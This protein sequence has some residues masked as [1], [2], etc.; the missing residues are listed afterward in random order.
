MLMSIDVQWWCY[1]YIYFR[2]NFI[3]LSVLFLCLFC[4]L[5]SIYSALSSIIYRRF[6]CIKVEWK[7][8]KIYRM[9]I[10]SIIVFFVSAY[11]RTDPKYV[12]YQVICKFAQNIRQIDVF[13]YGVLL[14][15][16][17]WG[18]KYRN[19]HTYHNKII[20]YLICIN[21]IEMIT[22]VFVQN[23]KGSKGY[24][25]SILQVY[26]LFA[27]IVINSVLQ[28]MK[29]QSNAKKEIISESFFVDKIQKKQETLFEERQEQL[30]EIYKKIHAYS[31]EEQMT[32]FV[33][34][35]WGGG[36]TFFS[37]ILY[38]KLKKTDNY[39]VI[40][41]DMNDFSETDILIKQIL[42]KIQLALEENNYYVG[43]SSEVEKYFDAVL[44]IT[45][46]KSLAKLISEYLKNSELNCI[47]N[48][49]SLTKMAQDF[50][51]M[52]GEGKIV[53]ILDDLDRCS[54]ETI[55]A[56]V[57][58]FSN[59]M[60]FPKSIVVFAGDYKQLLNKQD[61]TEGFFDKYFMY[62]YNLNPISYMK[63]LT[64]YQ[65]QYANKL[66][67]PIEFDIAVRVSRMISDINTWR[68]EEDKNGIA[69]M[70]NLDKGELR[71]EAI[72]QSRT[73]VNNLEKGIKKL[74]KQLSN[75]RRIIRIFNEIS[76]QL[77]IIDDIIE[78][79]NLKTMMY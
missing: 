63:L 52:L 38:E 76:D 46:N 35:E 26:I 45:V 53:I 73:L 65:R 11:A 21:F 36:K 40:W 24:I 15:L 51:D 18:M 13:L 30:E 27:I 78:E 29:F 71:K 54:E 33:S 14:I 74:E 32:I 25:Q 61:F 70:P 37:R 23:D 1:P 6:L 5:L 19:S 16:F 28:D 59:M 44:D 10:G 75:P 3:P 34:D 47:G 79:K 20:K 41:L 56:T 49:N 7:K 72:S 22:M 2:G 64:Y 43:S 57:K 9:F 8:Q 68:K 69:Q 12:L 42:K 17:F 50:S 62:N 55:S 48:G 60:Y 31:S 67:K 77:S 4:V 66:D 58:L 39:T